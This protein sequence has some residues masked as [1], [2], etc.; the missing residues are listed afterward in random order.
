VLFLSAL[1]QPPSARGVS[2]AYVT[3]FDAL[4][5]VRLDCALRSEEQ[6]LEYFAMHFD[7]DMTGH[8]ASGLKLTIWLR[9]DQASKRHGF[10]HRPAMHVRGFRLPEIAPEWVRLVVRTDPVAPGPSEATAADRR[11]CRER[12]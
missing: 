3:R 10:S 8:D 1:A 2:G 7:Y 5:A 4:S 12:R 11:G 6:V 9:H